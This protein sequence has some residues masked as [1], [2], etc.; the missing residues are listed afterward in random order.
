MRLHSEG[1]NSGMMTGESCNVT[2]QV[3]E[4]GI[5]GYQG[6]RRGLR[7][8]GPFVDRVWQVLWPSGNGWWWCRGS[9]SVGF[10]SV[11]LMLRVLLHHSRLSAQ[12]VRIRWRGEAEAD[13]RSI[14]NHTMMCFDEA[15]LKSHQRKLAGSFLLCGIF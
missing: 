4:R 3:W 6:E 2:G 12:Q 11:E 8:I 9:K 15:T 10:V 1:I 13:K 14:K 5:V 7:I